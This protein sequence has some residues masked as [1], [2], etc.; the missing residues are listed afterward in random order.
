MWIDRR[1]TAAPV[2]VRRRVSVAD[3]ALHDRFD[4][5][6]IDPIPVTEKRTPRLTAR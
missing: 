3:R 1:L 5:R 2:K 4:T 6:R